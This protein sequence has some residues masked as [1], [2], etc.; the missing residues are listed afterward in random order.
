MR[1]SCLMSECHYLLLRNWDLR[2]D[3]CWKSFTVNFLTPSWWSL[4]LAIWFL[5]AI[6]L[7][8]LTDFPQII[9]WRI[10]SVISR[11]AWRKRF[12]SSKLFSVFLNHCIWLFPTRGQFLCQKVLQYGLCSAHSVCFS[13]TYKSSRTKSYVKKVSLKFFSKFTGKGLYRSLFLNEVARR[14][15][16]TLIKNWL[17]YR[18]FPV[19]FAKTFK[20]TLLTEHLR[21]TASVLTIT[22]KKP[23]T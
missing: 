18:S 20:N 9:G 17:R 12:Q 13:N 15:F 5:L 10:R 22:S 3:S 2:T 19:N 4:Y 7:K 14:R 11:R 6:S 1:T 8:L 16:A 21:V 23:G